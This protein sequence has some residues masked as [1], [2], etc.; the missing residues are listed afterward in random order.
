MKKTRQKKRNKKSIKESPGFKIWGFFCGEQG[1][2]TGRGNRKN[3]EREPG[4]GTGS[5]REGEPEEPGGETGTYTGRKNREGSLTTLKLR[6]IQPGRGTG[7]G[8]LYLEVM[9]R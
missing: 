2:G 4:E 3:R 6:L 5:N 7:T 9:F 1:E 8:I